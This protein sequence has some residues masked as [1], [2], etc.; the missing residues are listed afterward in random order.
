MLHANKFDAIAALLVTVRPAL[1][2]MS[3][4][5]YPKSRGTLRLTSADPTAAPA[6]D[7]NYLG[8]QAEHRRR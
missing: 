2:I 4:L 7:P 8:E 5:I 3:T 6:I 1:R